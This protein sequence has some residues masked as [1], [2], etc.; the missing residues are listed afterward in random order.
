MRGTSVIASSG[1]AV[2]HS[3]HCTQFHS[4]KLKVGASP[5]AINAEAG[6]T[7]VQAIHKV[8]ASRSTTTSPNDALAGSAAAAAVP[9]VCS[10]K[11]SIAMRKV[12][13]FSLWVCLLYTSDAADDLLCVD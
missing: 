3:P 1:Q 8:Q 2:S 9:G 11:W 4:M 6:Q 12:L 13:R 5:P 7:E 10:Y